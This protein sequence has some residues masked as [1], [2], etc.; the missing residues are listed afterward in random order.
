[1]RYLYYYQVIERASSFYLSDTTKSTLNKILNSPDIQANADTYI[2][3]IIE[4]VNQDVKSDD[5]SK[6]EKIVK[7]LCDPTILWK[8]ISANIKFFSMPTS[9][10]GGFITNPIIAETADYAYFCNCW[11]PSLANQLRHIRNAIAHGR[12]K[13]FG[14]IIHPNENNDQLLLPWVSLIRR[15]AEQ[16]ILY[17]K[18]D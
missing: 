11:H 3:K 10:E 4:S 6:I 2:D 15:V 9:F 16:I 12:E 8:E 17:S 13:T 18:I 5:E 14:L 7:S 1:M